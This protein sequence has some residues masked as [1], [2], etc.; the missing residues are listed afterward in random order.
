MMTET[1]KNFLLSM[2]LQCRLTQ[3]QVET[4]YNNGKITAAERDEILNTPR[5]C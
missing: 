1:N 3:T 5:S 4:A 2:W